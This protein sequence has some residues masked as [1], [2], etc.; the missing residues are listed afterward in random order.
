MDRA[1][2]GGRWWK[3]L[4]PAA[5]LLAGAG[6]APQQTQPPLQ[7]AIAPP[8]AE[9]EPAP[10]PVDPL[11]QAPAAVQAAVRQYQQ[12]GQPPTI[13]G[14]RTLYPFDLTTR[15]PM[16]ICAPLHV[17]DLTLGQG[18]TV[19][20]IA[21]G[22]SERWLIEVAGGG[23]PHDPTP[24]VLIKP[25]DAPLRTNLVIM[26]T[27]R[28]YRLNLIARRG[29]EFTEAA[30]FYYPK[31]LL[32]ESA[33]AKRLAAD[34]PARPERTSLLAGLQYKQ[35]N[36]NYAIAGGR[37]GVKPVRCFDDGAHTYIQF[38]PDLAAGELPVLLVAGPAGNGLVNYRQAGNYLIVD[39]LYDQV[40]LLSGVGSAQD[41]V[42]VTYTGAPRAAQGA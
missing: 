4:G 19:T 24:H 32:A 6:C 28:T 29:G 3:V 18:E 14:E 9:R 5:A 7:L 33:A 40:V 10:A 25:K 26:T 42:T 16:L 1:A 22:D 34:P 31:E 39:G 36:L 30:G 12:S 37:N 2:V 38:G 8:A 13:H 27:R 15:P 23:D 17:T 21:T 35:L 11:T 20:D 41:R